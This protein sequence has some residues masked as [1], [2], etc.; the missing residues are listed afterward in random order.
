MLFALLVSSQTGK[1]NFLKNA[2]FSSTFAG[3]FH[4]CHPGCK[5]GSL[6]YCGGTYHN[7]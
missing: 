5:T 2:N 7:P 4:T 1:C 3:S 6:H